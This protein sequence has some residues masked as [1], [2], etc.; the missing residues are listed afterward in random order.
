MDCI[1]GLTTVPLPVYCVSVSVYTQSVSRVYS[2]LHPRL[3]ASTIAISPR[4]IKLTISP[5]A[6]LWHF[7]PNAIKLKVFKQPF[8]AHIVYTGELA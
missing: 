3:Y 5:I 6:L 1:C 2:R 7:P 8:I 4:G